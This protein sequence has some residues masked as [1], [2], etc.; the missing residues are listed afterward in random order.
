LVNVVDNK[1]TYYI[2]KAPI[3]TKTIAG[4]GVEE[5]YIPVYLLGNLTGQTVEYNTLT[6]MLEF[7]AEDNELPFED[8]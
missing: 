5:V 1:Y 2:L 6:Y 3:I 4:T 7:Y 8:D